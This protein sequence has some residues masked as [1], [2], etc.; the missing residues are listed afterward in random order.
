MQAVKGESNQWPY[1]G[2]KPVKDNS[3]QPSNRAPVV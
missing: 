2:G 1:P 3:G